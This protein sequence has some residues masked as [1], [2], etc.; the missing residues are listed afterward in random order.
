MGHNQT[1]NT[2]TRFTAI[3]QSLYY[4]VLDASLNV[5]YI[6]S[7]CIINGHDIRVK[8]EKVDKCS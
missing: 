6:G 4:L 5:K 1:D 8:I 7:V 3:Q 2:T